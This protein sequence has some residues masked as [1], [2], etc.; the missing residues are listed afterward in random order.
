MTT[1]LALALSL[2]LQQSDQLGLEPPKG[3]TAQEG[4][5][6]QEVPQKLSSNN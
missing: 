6:K 5:Q 4:P 3:W 1:L 2:C